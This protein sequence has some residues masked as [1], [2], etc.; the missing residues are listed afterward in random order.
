MRQEPT[1]PMPPVP[2]AARTPA[3]PTA[4]R[5][6]ATE[7]PD[8]PL[9]PVA[10]PL[11][12]AAAVFWPITRNYFYGDDLLAVYEA[13]HKPLLGFLFEP[14]GGHV[15]ATRN[16]LYLVLYQAFGPAPGAYY[17][18]VLLT[19]LANVALLFLI[20]RELAGSRLACF[21]AAL[22]GSAPINQAALGWYQAYGVVLAVTAQLWVLHRLVRLRRTGRLSRLEVA[23]W[24]LALLGASTCF[25]TGLAV[26]MAMPGVAWL[27]LPA[28]APRRRATLGL[29]AIAALIAVGYLGLQRLIAHFYPELVPFNLLSVALGAWRQ[30]LEIAWLMA[31]H[32][33]ALLLLGP[34][35]HFVAA[36]G[37]GEWALAVAFLAAAG[38]AFVAASAD[39]RRLM[40]AC[41]LP[42]AIGYLAI[43]SGRVLFWPS[44]GM[45]LVAQGHYH[46]TAPVTIAVL[47]ALMLGELARRWRPSAV[48][49]RGALALWFATFAALQLTVAP[50]V[51][52]H[53]RERKFA[54]RTLAAITTLVASQP[55]GADVFIENR[56]YPGVGPFVIQN[57][58]T[59]PGIAGLF[60]VYHPEQRLDGRRVFFVEANPDVRE[61]LRDRPFAAMLAP[62]EAVPADRVLHLPRWVELL[63]DRD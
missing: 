11:A 41:L 9:W 18:I 48:A 30:V 51:D 3:A 60:A 50:P 43:G 19:H 39:V 57:P 7:R 12:L 23:G 32:G 20:V 13:I 62:P 16:A 54:D 4:R 53:D 22:W 42:F 31:M 46:Y 25:G 56:P 58:Q 1:P 38:A 55:A 10:L 6:P 29:A 24:G 47:A 35:A 5:L 59:F 63:A 49:A 45:R 27:L 14:Y 36:G 61:H 52:H 2:D 21:G 8:G 34:F 28:A 40:L 33:L 15:M 17:L 37:A 44:L 26:T